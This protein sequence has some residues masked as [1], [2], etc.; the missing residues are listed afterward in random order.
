VPNGR[1]HR[2][3]L[4]DGDLPPGVT[5]VV[6]EMVAGE[7]RRIWVPAGLSYPRT[8]PFTGPLVFDLQVL[9]VYHGKNLVDD[10]E[11]EQP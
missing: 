2:A 4:E 1:P 7:R 11:A 8:H 5:E 6:A 10:V 3:E 9:A